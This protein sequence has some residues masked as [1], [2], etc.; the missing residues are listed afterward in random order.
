MAGPQGKSFFSMLVGV[1]APWSRKTYFILSYDHAEPH[2]IGGTITLDE[3][4][5]AGP[6][7]FDPAYLTHDHDMFVMHQALKTAFAFTS[8]EP[9]SSYLK[10]PTNGL[11][12]AIAS[13]GTDDASAMDEL[14]RNSLENGAHVVGT[15][16]MS[17]FDAE[18]GV[19][20]P[21]LRVKGLQGLRVVDA[22]VYVSIV[23]FL[24]YTVLAYLDQT[25]AIRSWRSHSTS[26]LWPGR[27]C[28]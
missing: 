23:S 20:N 13:V 2:F 4:N 26:H 17:P 18:W 3:A 28:G 6:P 14:V 5:P 7:L 27:A 24:A 12:E 19:V 11:A 1:V 21:D 8:A 16:S 22:S 25:S 9:F 10:T 15:A